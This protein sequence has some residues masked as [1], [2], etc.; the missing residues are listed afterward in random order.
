MFIAWGWIVFAAFVYVL[1]CVIAY[2]IG[3]S[4]DSPCLVQLHSDLEDYKGWLDDRERELTAANIE[5][6]KLLSDIHDK[7][8]RADEKNQQ[9]ESLAREN[10]QLRR[11]ILEAVNVL[12][13]S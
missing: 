1:S 13:E 8:S 12:T 10:A 11:M 4:C 5:R 7:A 9:I 3:A 6:E 2:A